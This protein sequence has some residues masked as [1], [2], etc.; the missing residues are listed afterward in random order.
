VIRMEEKRLMVAV[1]DML[2]N[3]VEASRKVEQPSQ[4]DRLEPA[5]LSVSDQTDIRTGSVV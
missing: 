3:A 5:G 1:E 2:A 4:A